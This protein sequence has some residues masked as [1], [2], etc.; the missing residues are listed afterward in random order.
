MIDSGTGIGD[1][2]DGISVFICITES[3]LEIQSTADV[4]LVKWLIISYAHKFA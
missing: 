3:L 2:M 1:V 4:D